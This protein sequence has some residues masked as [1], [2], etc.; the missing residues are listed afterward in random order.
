MEE[1]A[2]SLHG[3][4]DAET[5]KGKSRTGTKWTLEKKGWTI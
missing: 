5:K 3:D 1:Q 2:C 4:H